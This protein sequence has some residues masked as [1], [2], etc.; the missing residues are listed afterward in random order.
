M[1]RTQGPY[2]RE[3]L[4]LDLK[5]HPHHDDG[6]VGRSG[7]VVD[8]TRETLLLSDDQ[9]GF[10]VTKRPGTFEV[11]FLDGERKL[12]TGSRLAFRPQDRV[13]RGA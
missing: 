4:G 6:L 1:A 3:L 8:E 7:R 12:L 10:R 2:G 5:V 13:K 11:T 9:G